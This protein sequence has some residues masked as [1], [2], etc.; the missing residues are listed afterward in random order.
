MN[1]EKHKKIAVEEAFKIFIREDSKGQE[2]RNHYKRRVL[3]DEERRLMDLVPALAV[4]LMKRRVLSRPGVYSLLP[5]RITLLFLMSLL[6]SSSHLHDR[7]LM[8]SF[9]LYSS[10]MTD[11]ILIQ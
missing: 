10:F 5:G 8:A 1:D 9:N 6:S 2:R 7:D 11:A 3:G 4:R